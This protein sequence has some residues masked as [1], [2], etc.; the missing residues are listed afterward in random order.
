MAT[1]FGLRKSRPRQ[2]SVSAQDLNERS[3]PYDKTIP[4]RSP[5]PVGTLS[6]GFRGI[7]A[8]NT[9]PSLTTAGTE[10]N[11]FTTH[12]NRNDR[13]EQLRP[14]SPTASASTADS[15]TLYEEATG[16]LYSPNKLPIV[17]PQTARMRR[18]EDSSPRSQSQDFGQFPAPLHVQSSPLARPSSGTTLRSEANRYSKYAASL[19]SSDG[20]PHIP[21][22]MHQ[23]QA[24]ESFHFPRPPTDEEVEVLFEKV[25]LNRGDPKGF[26]SNL[27]IDQKW[28][29]VRSDEHMRWIEQK[30]G[31]HSRKQNEPGQQIPHESPQWYIQKF[32]DRTITPKQASSL[33]VCLRSKEMR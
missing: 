4:A 12:R 6:Q 17:H 2:S 14:G 19:T 33:N 29:L 9:N 16:P 31:Q 28:E 27:N 5:I 24:S 30:R 25:K 21:L 23:R 10:F 8:P 11:K 15:S 18:T 22:H 7:S 3:V 32:M 1:L 13:E 26:T 20:S